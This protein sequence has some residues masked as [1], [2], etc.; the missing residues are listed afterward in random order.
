MLDNGGA[1]GRRAAESMNLRF[2]ISEMHGHAARS[3]TVAA[4]IEFKR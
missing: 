3:L 2:E 4:L 1:D